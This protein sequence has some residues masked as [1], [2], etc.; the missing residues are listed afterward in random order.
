MTGRKTLQDIF[1]DRSSHL[2]RSANNFSRF[3]NEADLIDTS[4]LSLLCQQLIQIF[5]QLKP[6]DNQG[7]LS[8]EDK[9]KM[10]NWISM[11]L[12]HGCAEL[13]DGRGKL[14][15][16]Y[17]EKEKGIE[18]AIIAAAPIHALLFSYLTTVNEQVWGQLGKSLSYCSEQCT[19]FFT[20]I[21][22]QMHDLV[23]RVLIETQEPTQNIID[24]LFNELNACK[25][26]LSKMFEDFL[27][28]RK[29][30]P[31]AKNRMYYWLELMEILKLTE[32]EHFFPI[33]RC[34]YSMFDPIKDAALLNDCASKLKICKSAYQRMELENRKKGGQSSLV[35]LKRISVPGNEAPL[36]VIQP[37]KLRALVDEKKP[38]VESKLPPAERK[39]VPQVENFLEDWEEWEMPD[40]WLGDETFHD[41]IEDDW[42][43][44]SVANAK[45]KP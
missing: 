27:N 11:I 28:F 18:D 14:K 9:L 35:V 12:M 5:C 42:K 16:I 15:K 19:A 43:E 26:I 41:V 39:E 34:F 10:E 40:F 37:I 44:A 31:V 1:L 29:I 4:F 24:I 45:L 38:M 7:G 3:F 6:L 8:Q 13:L 23:A 32:S 25:L 30:P 20:F 22:N 21:Q 17:R 2:T 36:K 33:A